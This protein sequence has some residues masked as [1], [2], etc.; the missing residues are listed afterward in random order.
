MFTEYKDTIAEGDLVI[1][2]F[3]PQSSFPIRMVKDGCFN[4]KF[5]YYLHN[6]AI[7]RRYGTRLMGRGKRQV[8]RA[9][10]RRPGSGGATTSGTTTTTGT[11]GTTTNEEGRPV[12]AYLLHPTPELW[13]M[14]LPHRTQIIY[15]PDISFI[16]MGLDLGPGKRV[17]ESG[18]GSA[19]FTHA[20]ARTVCGPRLT[21]GDV[22]GDVGGDSG[23]GAT[24]AT[25][26]PSDNP[27]DHPSSST[28]V[29]TTSRQGHV[30]TFEYHETRMQAARQELLDHGCA[31]VVT[32]THRDVYNGG[33][34]LAG[35]I[36]G[37]LDCV[38]SIDGTCPSPSSSSVLSSLDGAIDAVFLDLP[39]PWR[40]VEHCGRLFR[41]GGVGRV[42]C[43]S[44]CIE[45]VQR[46]CDALRKH[47]FT[48]ILMYECL[49]RTWDVKRIPMPS[50]V[51]KIAA[52]APV[53]ADDTT[54]TTGST[55]TDLSKKSQRG[56]KRKLA[57]VDAGDHGD[58][59]QNDDNDQDDTHADVVD[60]DA[61]EADHRTTTETTTTTANTTNTNNS[62]TT[63][64]GYVRR[65]MKGHTAF[66]T[67]AS[68]LPRC[69]DVVEED[70]VGVVV[71]EKDDEERVAVVEGELDSDPKADDA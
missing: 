6:D 27:S 56:V 67:F 9:G 51:N 4:G 55:T 59:H 13:T 58:D 28:P 49:E 14:L 35:D 44:P 31:D 42:C 10:R 39:E 36:H 18:T 60:D 48:D 62:A 53:G 7:G 61:Q 66:L 45:Q 46:T 38:S 64:L 71:E 65:G 33:F 5:G 15:T 30:Y 41:R 17:V 32:V 1:F 26:N 25:I 24:D 40:A 54:T 29:T 43:F 21:G 2:Y 63:H 68:Y 34:Q 11:T 70:V 69:D 19:S 3:T 52:A 16:T 57:P 22:G 8:I 47:G 12:A 23:G 20:L 37:G 50:L